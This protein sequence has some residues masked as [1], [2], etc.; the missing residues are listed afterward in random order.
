MT[1]TIQVKGLPITTK[2]NSGDEYISLTDI[3]KYKSKRFPRDIIKN[4]TR[5]KET[6]LY[7][8]LWETLNNPNFK[9]VEFD[10]FKME[11]GIGS[12]ILS[13]QNWIKKTNAIGIISKSGRYGG[14]FAHKDIAFEFASWISTEFKLYLITE[15]KRLKLKEHTKKNLEWNL[16]RDI[17][18]VNYEI[19]TDAIKN[20]LIPKE[21][22]KEEA[23]QIYASEAEI[24]NKAIFGLTSQEWSKLESNKKEKIRDKAN[25]YQLICISNLEC[26][27]SELI[28]KNIPQN[29]RLFKL[30]KIAISQ[31]KILTK[32]I[33]A[34]RLNESL[35]D[36]GKILPKNGKPK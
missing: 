8:G 17:S 21:I 5:L 36:T 15:F 26:I 24:I 35:P 14:T 20:N 25:I 11:A 4:W 9:Q 29:K 31:M 16:R 12:F 3:A 30:N 13:P 27:N 7:L 19:Q 18:K 2:S 34:K 33:T 23:N 1:P 22:S 28:K 10:R 6:I 32:N